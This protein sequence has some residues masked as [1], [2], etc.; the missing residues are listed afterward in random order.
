MLTAA[1][2]ALCDLRQHGSPVT[3]FLFHRAVIMPLAPP[4]ITE[5]WQ[6]VKAS[7]CTLHVQLKLLRSGKMNI[8]AFISDGQF[9]PPGTRAL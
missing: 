7:L 2:F 4:A 1:T 3:N 6:V 9:G 5:S 8:Q